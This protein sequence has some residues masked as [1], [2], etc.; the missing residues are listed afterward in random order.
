MNEDSI[1]AVQVFDQKKF[2]KKDQ[3]FLGVINI[4]IGDLIELAPDADGTAPLQPPSPPCILTQLI[5]KRFADQMLTKDLKKSTDNLV[6]HGKLIVNLSTNLT[7]P[8]RGQQGPASPSR[9]SLGPT[10]QGSNV[11]T[12][13][14]ERG[15]ERPVSAL[16]GPNGT[17]HHTGPQMTIPHRPAS[18]VQPTTTSNAAGPTERPRHN[19]ALSPFED[20][21]GRLP[22]GWERREDNLGR[23]YYVDHNTRTTSWNRPTASGATAEARDNREA[24]T[25]VE[26][27]R[28]QNRTL[29][30]DRTGANSPSLPGQGEQTPPSPTMRQRL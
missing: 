12:L 25:Q 9:S 7:T 15:A 26:R 20:A 8:P 27:Q 13:T 24:A 21:Q 19:S 18:M 23:T 10:P 3:G 22:A 11:S 14:P 17:A 1:L 5:A 6:V 28:H 29:P 16:S 30:E 2:K 4:R